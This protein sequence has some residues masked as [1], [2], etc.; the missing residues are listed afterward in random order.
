MWTDC[1]AGYDSYKAALEEC[2]GTEQCGVDYGK[3]VDDLAECTDTLDT[4]D[5]ALEE[6]RRE[7]EKRDC[8]MGSEVYDP[9]FGMCIP[10][11]DACDDPL[12]R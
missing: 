2:R 5:A 1:K 11:C 8:F 9:M 10:K 3:A 6:Q 12:C 4:C 7:L